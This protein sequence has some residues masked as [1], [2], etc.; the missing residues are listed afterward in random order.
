VSN[1]GI[2][3]DWDRE[4]RVGVAEAVLCAGKTTEQIGRIVALAVARNRSLLLTKLDASRFTELEPTVRERLNFDPLSRTGV[5]DNGLPISVPA[6]VGI[7]CAGTSDLAIGIEAQR[8]LA[9]H[10][11][12][13]PL[14][15]DVG[16]AGLWRFL[17]HLEQIA[18]WR[19]VIVVA[20]MEGAL[21]S[22]AAGQV[23]GLVIAVPTSVGYGVATGG[24]TALH[25]A[26]ASCA[27]GVVTVNIDNGFGAACAAV[28]LLRVFAPSR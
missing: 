4:T 22:V 5:L 25:S 23:R 13:A 6:G 12:Q 11:V 10:G 24:A 9:F 2:V 20:G 14:I 19:I 3:L 8:A 15:A 21:F 26:L 7:V 1:E 27:P 18:A 16:V 28:K 17:D